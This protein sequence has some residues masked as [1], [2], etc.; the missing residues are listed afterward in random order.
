MKSVLRI[1]IV[2]LSPKAIEY[3]FALNILDNK[4]RQNRYFKN[5]LDKGARK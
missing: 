2:A 5:N 4:K 3:P 1:V